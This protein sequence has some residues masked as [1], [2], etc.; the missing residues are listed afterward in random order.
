MKT[1]LLHI[2]LVSIITSF[3]ASCGS[4]S[5]TIT[6][7]TDDLR[8]I[9]LEISDDG[10]YT[11]VDTKTG[12]SRGCYDY[13]SLYH[14]GYALV[15]PCNS[16]GFIYIDH[17]QEQAIPDTF[18]YA[19]NF[20]EGIAFVARRGQHISAINTKGKTLFDLKEVETVSE[21]H[22]GVA[23]CVCDENYGL[24]DSKGNI[25]TLPSFYS[26]TN[27]FINDLMAVY[28]FGDDCSGWGL[29]NR[30]GEKITSCG[31]ERI[32][33]SQDD[34]LNSL[35]RYNSV[36]AL[37]QE[38]IPVCVDGQWGVI[39]AEGK[40]IINP[41][42]DLIVLDGDNYLFRKDRRYGWCDSKGKYI[43]NPQF[44]YAKPSEGARLMA[45]KNDD[46]YGYID[47]N[48]KWVIEAQFRDALPFRSSGTAFVKDKSG[49]W[50]AIN[51]KGEWVINPQ[52][53]GII[54]ISDD[55]TMVTVGRNRKIGIIN[56][57]GEYLVNP[58]YEDLTKELL[59]NR[60]GMFVTYAQSDF[61]DVSVIA[62]SIAEALYEVKTQT[63]GDLKNDLGEKV[64]SKDGGDVIIYNTNLMRNVD[65]K[66]KARKI[67]AWNRVSDGWFG[68]KY[69]FLSN[70]N[71]SSY[72]AT[73]TFDD[74]I[75]RFTNEI[76][77]ALIT[78]LSSIP[79]A[80]VVHESEV[81]IKTPDREYTVI[82]LID[83]II[84]YIK[85]KQ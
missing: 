48:G 26:T 24:V 22:D 42:F 40:Y 3:F 68:Y 58:E 7:G 16:E 80:E 54:P 11:Y 36:I 5:D 29:I 83:H 12:Q 50:G 69:V 61:V 63:T 4:G 44:N 15:S 18:A 65:I 85:T 67:N 2:L 45:V 23:L 57:K 33:Y 51:E 46:G 28:G 47:R 39:N 32:I 14:E 84:I 19:T 78:Q 35:T 27:Y 21:L 79:S 1:K 37:E 8:Y 77:D 31:Y 75:A 74:K 10:T 66:L 52:F 81:V 73:V 49:D 9:P 72:S 71:V 13:A 53:D 25:T 38:R 60:Y 55:I 30:K 56:A 20:S 59:Y 43:I 34:F 6:F 17:N 41:Q 82:P 62:S 64:F 70:I 76:A